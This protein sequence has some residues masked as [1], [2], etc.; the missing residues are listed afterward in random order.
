MT[1]NPLLI[2]PKPL[3]TQRTSRSPTPLSTDAPPQGPP[4]M[5]CATIKVHFLSQNNLF[6]EEIE[7]NGLILG[8]A[9]RHSSSLLRRFDRIK[10]KSINRSHLLA[11]ATSFCFFPTYKP[12]PSKLFKLCESSE[13]GSPQSSTQ[14]FSDSMVPKVCDDVC[15]RSRLLRQHR[16]QVLE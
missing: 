13:F 7:R 16:K 6:G 10:S 14:L 5:S 8:D 2:V 11:T 12:H 1:L 4:C 15:S 9:N 3:H